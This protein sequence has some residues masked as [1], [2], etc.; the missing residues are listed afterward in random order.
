MKSINRKGRKEYAQ[1]SQS[2]DF[3]GFVFVDFVACL[4]K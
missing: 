1:R 4:R 3:Y 2:I